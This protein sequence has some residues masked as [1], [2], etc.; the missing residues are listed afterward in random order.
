MD[1]ALYRKTRETLHAVAELVIAGPQHREFGTIRLGVVEG[2]FGGVTLPVSV[3]GAELVWD[4]GRAPLSGSY[5]ELAALAGV[6]AGPP[7]GVYQDTTEMDLDAEVKV[8]A[9]SVAV[10]EDWFRIGDAALRRL[11][12]EATPVL[13]PE[14][15]DLAVTADEVNY[16][17]SPG[18][19]AHPRPYAYV[20]PWTPRTGAFWN[21]SFGALRPRDELGTVAD[22][23]A[24]FE[25][26]RVR[27]QA[28]D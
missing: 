10:L 7:E 24:F 17:V 16:G 4:G 25:E 2:G 12:P 26:G 14:H 9:E 8:D 27:A 23:L 11:L 18:D 28:P 19:S 22:L 13:W 6:Q 5:R 21:A 20:G 15:F 3:R 1:D